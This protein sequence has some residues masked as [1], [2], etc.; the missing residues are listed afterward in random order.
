MKI[1]LLEELDC[2]GESSSV[3][4]AYSS[5]EKALHEQK[6]Y[7]EK[8]KVASKCLDCPLYKCDDIYSEECLEQDNCSDCEVMKSA[9]EK[10]AQ[11][12][13]EY[14]FDDDEYNMC[15]NHHTPDGSYAYYIYEC[16]LIE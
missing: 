16:E 13:T 12:C 15:A 14:E 5:Y 7:E 9:I 3:I 4:A 11:Y 10:I 1:Y 8:E 2:W 6:K